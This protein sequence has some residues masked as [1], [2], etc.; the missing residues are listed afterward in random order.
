MLLAAQGNGLNLAGKDLTV[1][2]LLTQRGFARDIRD[3]Q[4]YYHCTVKGNQPKL[5][6]DLEL[7]FQSRPAKPDFEELSV[8]HGR[9]EARRIWVTQALNGYLDFP[10]IRQAFLIQREVIT[11][12]TG[13]VSSELAYCITSRPA[14]GASGANP[15]RLLQIN[16]RHWTIENRCHWV[17]DW[18]F[19]EDRGTIRTGYGPE[20]ISRLRRFAASLI[21]SK[22]KTVAKTLRYLDRHVRT[23]FDFLLM[24][25]NSRRRVAA[26]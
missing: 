19:D 17:I 13:K 1:D 9:I 3:L 6:A 18:N 7:H 26:A 5:L 23:V 14:S 2:A 24:T 21:Q 25:E 20:N 8:G 15:E 22:G 4:A 11:K 12:K 10:D 16:R